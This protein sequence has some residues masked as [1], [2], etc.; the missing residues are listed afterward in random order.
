MLAFADAEGL[1]VPR[2]SVQGAAVTDWQDGPEPRLNRGALALD[3]R[4]W[5]RSVALTSAGEVLLGTDRNLYAFDRKGAPRWK[6]PVPGVAWC[7]NV[8][9][10]GRL[11]AAALGDGTIRWYRMD[12]GRELL[13]LFAHQ[14]GK[15][16]VA[17]TPAGYYDCSPGGEDLFGWHVN[18]GKE[19]AADFFPAFAT[20][21]RQ[22]TA[23]RFRS[24]FHSPEVV[25]RAL[26]LDDPSAPASDD[27]FGQ[28]VR[29]AQA[30]GVL[31]ITGLNRSMPNYQVVF[32][33]FS[34]RYGIP[35][36]LLAPVVTYFDRTQLLR[37]NVGGEGGLA[38]GP[39]LVE[40][41]PALCSV[42]KAEGLSAPYKVRTWDSIPD[43]FKDPD[44]YWSGGYYG[45]LVLEVNI[46]QTTVIPRDW[47]D[48]LGPD[49]PGTLALTG[50][51]VW[52]QLA[53]LAAV[54]A[55]ARAATGN[56]A[57]PWAGLLFFSRL[58]AAGRLKAGM[59]SWKT[60]D[61][62]SNL[63]QAWWDF[64]AMRNQESNG[65]G[66]VTVIPASGL[67]AGVFVQAISACAPHPNAARLFEEFLL[68]DEGQ[69]LLLEGHVHPARLDDLVQRGAVS[70]QQLASLPVVP[71]G[72]EICFPTPEELEAVR[73]ACEQH[74]EDLVGVPIAY[75]WGL[76]GKPGDH[77]ATQ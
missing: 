17:W 65:P 59:G 8:S 58:N 44:G 19:T 9:A 35:V 75:R 40:L 76:P 69:L 71:F 46:L 11:G 38:R 25:S 2:I 12:D 54:A 72:V 4:E 77:P 18:R 30:E 16:W 74:W 6:R 48:L 28:L 7:V 63:V 67:I 33:A 41:D 43:A 5:S 1:R 51:P 45:N 37:D 20:A 49:F 57:D 68:S 53:G 62:T 61:F 47:D 21:D 15:R 3:S 50:D 36:V 27:A 52:G 22:D 32:D 39:D 13:A 66:T 10:D 34:A 42:L 24:L 29:A 56:L 55:A 60:L 31:S 14:D 64:N 26:D 73:V 70:D 23:S